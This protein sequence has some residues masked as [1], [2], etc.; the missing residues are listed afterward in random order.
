M[1]PTY[2]LAAILLGASLATLS[3]CAQRQDEAQVP[4]PA[5]EA[6]PPEA[7][8]PGHDLTAYESCL[9]SCNQQTPGQRAATTARTASTFRNPL[10][11]SGAL[12]TR[13]RGDQGLPL[14]AAQA[15]CLSACDAL[16]EGTN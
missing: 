1:K 5:A 13:T 7:P 14:R 3:A 15:H 12:A 8:A 11:N 4:S 10:S 2:A 9:A 6:A 16:R